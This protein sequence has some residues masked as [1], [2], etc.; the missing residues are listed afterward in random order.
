MKYYHYPKNH[1]V[2]NM[3]DKIAHLIKEVANTILKFGDSDISRLEATFRIYIICIGQPILHKCTAYEYT[4]LLRRSKV[5]IK[6]K[7]LVTKFNMCGE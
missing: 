4:D 6:E 7:F 3:K 2:Q 5:Y 1:S